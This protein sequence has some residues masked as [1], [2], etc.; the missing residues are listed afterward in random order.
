MTASETAA[1]SHRRHRSRLHGA[2]A[3]R[4]HPSGVGR[5]PGGDRRPASTRRRGSRVSD[6]SRTPRRCWK[7]SSSMR[8]SSPTRT[9]C[10]STRPSN[11]SRPASRCS[12][13]SRSPWTTRES[14]RLV[15][16]VARLDGR[17]L[18]GHHRRHH[19][20]DRP[21]PHRDPRRRARTGRRRQRTLVGAQRGRVLHAT[22]PGTAEHGAGVM[23][24]NVVHDLDL[25][26]HLCGEVAEIQAMQSSHA[27]G[28]EVE[29]TVSLNLRFESGAVGS[30][31][32]SDAG[33]SPVGLG[34]GHRRD[35]RVPVPPGRRRLPARRHARRAVGAEP[36]EVL[37]RPVGVRRLALAPVAHLPSRSRRGARSRRSS[38]TSS[39]SRV[40][41]RSP[42]SRPRTHRGRSRSSRRRHWP[43]AP[44]RRSTSHDS[45]PT[46][47]R[48][49]SR[50]PA[51][52]EERQR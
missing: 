37:L 32:A 50:D 38:T 40:E 21:C 23:L 27:R 43:P 46:S 4:L 11:A 41:R 10:T 33:V 25:L 45:G 6:L 34:P 49:S 12:S 13:R 1:A 42:S 26:R 8:S 39:R 3:H 17:L 24:I 35:A 5:G 47:T 31:L 19:P 36:R 44:A 20:A 30:F 2:P 51:R 15:D 18:V 14:R 29:D 7:Q 9:R 52:D 22:R 48:R 16:A 28:L